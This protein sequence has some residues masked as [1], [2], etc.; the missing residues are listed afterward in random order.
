MQVTKVDLSKLK[1]TRNN[2]TSLISN[3]Q[4]KWIAL[5]SLLII[6]VG[7]SYPSTHKIII[8]Q[9]CM[10]ISIISNV[11]LNLIL[12]FFMWGIIVDKITKHRPKWVGWT[13]WGTGMLCMIVFLTKGAGFETRFI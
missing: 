1:S 5:Y 2:L 3:W 8:D 4:Y 11:T 7:A 13:V 10:F 6:G 9:S 12:A